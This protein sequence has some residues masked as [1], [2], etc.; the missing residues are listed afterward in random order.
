M[1]VKYLYKTKSEQ[2]KKFRSHQHGSRFQH[3]IDRCEIYQNQKN[4]EK[5]EREREKILR[6]ANQTGKL[7]ELYIFHEMKNIFGVVVYHVNQSIH[8]TFN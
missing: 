1:V 8:F 5:G 3:A 7:S 6:R 2:H 4:T